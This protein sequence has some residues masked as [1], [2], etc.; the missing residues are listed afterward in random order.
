MR[1]HLEDA[2]ENIRRAYQSEQ[3]RLTKTPTSDALGALYK[4]VE[5]LIERVEFL[6]SQVG[7]LS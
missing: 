2:R 5:A 6:E 7:D 3:A 4:T 1:V